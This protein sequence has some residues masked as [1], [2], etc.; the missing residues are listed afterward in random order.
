MLNESN[1]SERSSTCILY[2]KIG[3]EASFKNK[4]VYAYNYSM[5][6]QFY[7]HM[8]NQNRFVWKPVLRHNLYAIDSTYRYLLGNSSIIPST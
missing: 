7:I 3:V 5:C 2:I 6:T 1:I 8:G 4:N